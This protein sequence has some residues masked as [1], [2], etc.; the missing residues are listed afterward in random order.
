MSLLDA[1]LVLVK[2]VK[3]E[4]KQKFTFSSEQCYFT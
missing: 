2:L 1:S 4:E 3:K